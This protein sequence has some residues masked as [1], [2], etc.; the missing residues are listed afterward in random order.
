[1]IMIQ[2]ILTP[3]RRRE[4]KGENA[5]TKIETEILLALVAWRDKDRDGDSVS[6]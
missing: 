2:P 4:T 5:E 3:D 6:W 1:M